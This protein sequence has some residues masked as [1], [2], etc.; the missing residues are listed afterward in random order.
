M[1]DKIIRI[2]SYDETIPHKMSETKT[3]RAE[4]KVNHSLLGGPLS[5]LIPSS[6]KTLQ[7]RLQLQ[8]PPTAFN[9][10][11]PSLSDHISKLRL[12]IVGI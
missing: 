10:M 4:L 3:K 11:Y 9:V 1:F 8:N 7:R 2:E 6:V 12:S 5:L